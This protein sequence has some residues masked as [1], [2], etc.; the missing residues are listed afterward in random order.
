MK[1]WR[2]NLLIGVGVALLICLSVNLVIER[3]VVNGSSMLPGLADDQR[4]I[5]LTAAYDFTSPQ[6]GDVIIIH[7]PVAP[8][9]LWI[10]RLIG[11]P[12]DILSI[13][14]G[15]VYLNGVAL[16]EP[17]IKNKPLYSFGPFT[18]PAG[19]YFV[20]GDNRNNST[21]SHYGWTV[22]RENIVGKAWLCYWP[23]N[24]AGIVH[25]Y[26]ITGE[27]AIADQ[28]GSPATEKQSFSA[29]NDQSAPS[30]GN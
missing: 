3:A 16:D 4:L 27:L 9:K 24:Q 29:L 12:G 10:K 11:L 13:Q 22:S 25:A 2:R 18:V 30:V 28:I 21:D 7:P 15:R 6:R 23:F 19:H 1:N 14:G 20:L 26:D 5:I 8:E 17:Y